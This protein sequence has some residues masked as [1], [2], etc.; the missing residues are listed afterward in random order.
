MQV[1]LYIFPPRL[2]KFC[3]TIL[4]SIEKD[5]KLEYVITD[6]ISCAEDMKYKS[7]QMVTHFVLL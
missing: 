1:F 7:K 3:V 4:E 2:G 5:V 6:T